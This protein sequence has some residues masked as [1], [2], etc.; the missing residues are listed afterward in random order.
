MQAT[1]HNICLGAGF[2][3]SFAAIGNIMIIEEYFEELLMEFTLSLKFW[4]TRTFVSLA[5]CQSILISLFPTP[6]G[7]SVIKSNLFYSFV[8]CLECLLIVFCLSCMLSGCLAEGFNDVQ[9]DLSHNPASSL[10]S[11]RVDFILEAG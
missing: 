9:Y 4:R 6:R 7:W 11:R 8:L 1:T 3:A 10:Q 5:V 2:I